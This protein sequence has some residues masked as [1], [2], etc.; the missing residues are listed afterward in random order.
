M[1]NLNCK[2]LEENIRG[3]SLCDLMLGDNYLDVTLKSLS[4]KEQL[5]K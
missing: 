3:K 4:I 1:L 5:D 2:L